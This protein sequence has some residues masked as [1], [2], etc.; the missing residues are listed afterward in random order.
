MFEKKVNEISQRL[1]KYRK[2]GILTS[3]NKGFA[4]KIKNIYSSVLFFILKPL[5]NQQN[6]YNHAL[7]GFSGQVTGHTEEIDKQL[8]K[9]SQDIQDLTKRLEKLEYRVLVNFPPDFDYSQ[10]EDQFRGSEH[11]VA[12]RQKLYLS[13]L[14][15]DL[16]TLDI[17]CGRG[18]F[19]QLL[20]QNGF[21]ARG[22]DMDGRM[23]ARCKQKGLEAEMADAV[24][25]IQQHNGKLGNIFLSQIVEHMDYKDIYTLVK[26]CW[27]KMEPEATILIETI[28]PGSFY[29]QSTTYVLDPT[30]VNLVSPETLSY[31]FQ[32]VG[33][34]NLR[35]IYKSPVP[36]EQRL[37]MLNSSAGDK[38]IDRIILEINEDLKKIDDIMFGNLEY[39][40]MG[41]K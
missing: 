14:N 9:I 5:I 15:K 35:I 34:G 13:Y 2:L 6:A 36:P 38:K 18:E 25:Y 21:R 11:L 37:H 28:N 41:V 1:E 30:H 40:I 10:F 33:F 12:E 29:A 26:S 22:I 39:A 17:G 8:D 31:T 16:E 27:E 4:R 32:K 20:S 24:S 7:Y 23:V 3:A 19:L